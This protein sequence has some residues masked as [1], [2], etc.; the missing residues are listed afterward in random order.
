MRLPGT[1]TPK[2]LA[3]LIGGRA[4]FRGTMLLANLV[5]LAV[6]GATDYAGY[7]QAMGS[8]AFLAPLASIGIEKC[9]LKLIPRLRHTVGSLV[10]VFVTLAGLLFLVALAVL[11]TV[12]AVGRPEAWLLAGLAG[13]YMICVGVNQVLLGLARALGRPGRDVANHLVLCVALACWTGAAAFLDA[14]PTVFLALCATTTAV[15]NVVALVLLRPRFGG[16]RRRSLVRAAVGTSLLMSVADLVG[17]LSMSLLFVALSVSGAQAES[18]GLYLASAAS[19]VLLNAFSY[20]LRILQP[21]VSR[22]LHQRDLTAAYDR[23]SRWL[24]LLVLA[25]TPYVL[26]VL[27]VALAVLRPY[28]GVGVV[29][30]YIA[31][32]PVI[33]AAG[34]ANYMMENASTEAL[35]ATAAGAAVSLLAVA[36]LAFLT[37]PLAGA[38][39]AVTVLAF[40]ELVHAAMILRW[41]RS[42]RAP[43]PRLVP[44]REHAR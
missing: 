22:S 14:T 36:A 4:A 43:S 20:L 38:L 27:G 2:R 13:L 42:R 18:T 26:T 19:S 16:L 12:L 24:R 40:G 30:V 7:A 44:G 17:G 29:I 41:L 21:D 5:L 34:S 32:V 3:A 31:C 11:G 23:L 39:G 35:T 25:G 33:F 6:W 9:A 15:L 8:M 10:G 28:G 1:A 37:V